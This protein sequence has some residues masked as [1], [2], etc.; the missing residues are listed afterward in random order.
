VSESLKTRFSHREAGFSLPHWV[1]GDIMTYRHEYGSFG[2][3]G[4]T[5][6]KTETLHPMVLF[7]VC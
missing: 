4:H 5:A 2:G 3:T 6:K 1:S 7:G